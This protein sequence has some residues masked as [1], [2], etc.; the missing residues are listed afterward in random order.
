M[1]LAELLV[2]AGSVGALFLHDAGLI[3]QDMDL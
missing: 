3:P 2:L 1:E